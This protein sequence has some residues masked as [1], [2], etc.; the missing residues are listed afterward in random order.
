MKKITVKFTSYNSVIP[1]KIVVLISLNIDLKKK[2][3]IKNKLNS[4]FLLFKIFKNF[5]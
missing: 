5:F 1:I 4:N 3:Y 2:K